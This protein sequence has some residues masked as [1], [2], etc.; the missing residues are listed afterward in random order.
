MNHTNPQARLPRL[1]TADQVA[2]A[3]SLPKHRV[4]ELGREGIMPCIRIGRSMRFD[5]NAVRAWLDEGGGRHPAPS[6][7]DPYKP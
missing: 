5:A 6:T 7:R 4:Y 2:E 3:M 1:L